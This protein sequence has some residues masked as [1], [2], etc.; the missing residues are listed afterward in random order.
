M[1]T[2]QP[3]WR[4]LDNLGDRTPIDYGGYFV[5][6]DTT[7]V[8]PPEVELLEPPPDDVEDPD[9][10]RWTIYRFT[11][12]RCTFQNGVLS[13]NPYHPEIPAWFASTDHDRPQDTTRIANLANYTGSAE[14][15]LIRGFC[16]E[17][18]IARADAYR[19]VGD[20]HGFDNLDQYPLILNREEVEH[21]YNGIV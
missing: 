10:M 12:A 20:Y 17:D 2:N 18:P 19:T 4:L 15:D 8:Y 6:E 14:L 3:T 1:T 21:R 5:F 11:P 13:D 9:R 16:S 7:G